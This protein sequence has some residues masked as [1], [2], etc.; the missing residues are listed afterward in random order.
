MPVIANKELPPSCVAL[1]AGRLSPRRRI[2]PQNHFRWSIVSGNKYSG[3]RA[4]LLRDLKWV[5]LD[6]SWAVKFAQ[7]KLDVEDKISDQ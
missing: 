6:A 1:Q 3:V 2:N 4:S 7:L 5:L